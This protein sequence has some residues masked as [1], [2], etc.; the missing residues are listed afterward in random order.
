MEKP[1]ST[2]HR[3]KAAVGEALWEAMKKEGATE[4]LMSHV[5]QMTLYLVPD[6]PDTPGAYDNL[7]AG[8]VECAWKC[9]VH[10]CL[11]AQ[12]MGA[13]TGIEPKVHQGQ[14]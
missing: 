2:Y 13:L 7:I 10:D 3:T 14:N 11:M 4:K 5:S 9:G 1:M 8:I 6:E 12:E